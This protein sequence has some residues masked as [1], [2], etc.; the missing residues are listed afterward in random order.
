MW[1]ETISSIRLRA[2][3]EIG[4]KGGEKEEK[5]CCLIRENVLFCNNGILDTQ[6]I[7]PDPCGKSV[8]LFLKMAGD[9]INHDLLL[10]LPLQCLSRVCPQSTSPARKDKCS[11][12]WRWLMIGRPSVIRLKHLRS[13]CWC[14]PHLNS[15]SLFWNLTFW[16]EQ[17]QCATPNFC[18]ISN[19]LLFV[20]DLSLFPLL[21]L[22]S[23]KPLAT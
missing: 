9:K 17:E 11:E 15:F 19:L 8:C 10:A 22:L 21:H 16:Q 5:W 13:Y 20:T 12:K 2:F 23:P 18:H 14:F 3:G 4:E 6:S 1:L 7:S